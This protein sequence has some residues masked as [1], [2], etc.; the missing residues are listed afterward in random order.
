MS[1]FGQPGAS[2]RT[3]LS[4]VMT[5][6]LLDSATHDHRY[7]DDVYARALD[8]RDARFDGIFFVGIVTTRIYCRPVCP[9]RVSH[10]SHR[11]FFTSAAAAEC[12]GF[13]PCL[14]CR[15]ELAPGRA[16]IDAVPRLAD[17]AAQR[18]AAGALNG[19]SVAALAREL[20][21]S[22]RHL[23]R[24]HERELGV[25]PVELAQTHRVLLA[26]RLLADT[27]LSVTRIA[28]SSGFQSLRRFNAAFR[29]AY[30][31]PPSSV[32][33]PV[34]V[35]RTAQAMPET[36]AEFLWLTLAYR[37]PLAWEV[38]LGL[39]A[40]DAVS[41]VELVQDRRYS[42]TVRIADRSGVSLVED[43]IPVM[44][45]AGRQDPV[46][47][48][49]LRVGVSPSLVPAL[50][51]L[52]SR[53]RHV[54]DLDAEPTAID[55]HLSNGGLAELVNRRPGLR[56]P[57]AMD[58]FDVALRIMLR[59]RAWPAATRPPLRDVVW[60]VMSV[61]GEPI[62][63]GLPELSWLAPSAE[64]VAE[65]GGDR[66][67]ALGVPRRRAEG[68]VALARAIADGS[69]CLEPGSDPEVLRTALKDLTGAGD[70]LVS[71]I[72]MRTLNWPDAF[73]VSQPAVQRAAGVSS[74]HELRIRAESWRP[75]RAYAALHL[76]LYA[77][78]IKA[79]TAQF[80][81]P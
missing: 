30:R 53:L 33:R 6:P 10:Q 36:P 27:A 59:G 57:G 46:T 56:I 48:T 23:R 41:G 73:P 14:R 70:R 29:A 20:G 58:G 13:R 16:M 61:L 68:A 80:P 1:E 15:P 79:S 50:M 72:L 63:T 22:E 28:Y 19:R 67:A 44:N 34:I 9:A 26:K 17:A 18:I 38:L 78:D 52:L 47:H 64:R 3:Y 21:V 81:E 39:L 2:R 7:R 5:Q 4:D 66:L 76:W 37:A 75:W 74:S 51:P 45:A 62:E 55:A 35:R 42:R 77:Q 8:A 11:R 24:A 65:A 12:A 32:R 25:S 43:M 31:M 60:R 40:R 49:H 69:V 71:M 54:F